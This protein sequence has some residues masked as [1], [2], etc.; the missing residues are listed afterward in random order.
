MSTH[1]NRRGLTAS[2]AGLA[3]SAAVLTPPA[4]AQI[5]PERVYY[6]IDRPVEMRVQAPAGEPGEL[7]IALFDPAGTEPIASASVAA[8]RVDLAGLFPSLWKPGAPRVRYAQ[9]LADQHRVGPPVVLQMLTTP[10]HAVADPSTGRVFFKDLP[11]TVSGLRAY[12][13][14]LVVFETDKGPITFRMRPDQAPNTVWNFLQ[15]VEGGFYTDIIFH[16]ILP[17]G[18]DGY[19]FVVQVGDPTGT[20]SGGPGYFIDLE[21][22]KL[23]HDFGVLSMARSSDPNSGGSQIFICL[24]RQATR[25][26]DGAYTSFA[27]AVSGADVIRAIQNVELADERAGKPRTPPRI[28]SARLEDAPPFGQ[29]PAP[30]SASP[31]KTKPID[32]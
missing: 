26:L 30:L 16:R 5:Q 11:E 24:S 21:P 23:P 20:G 25:H 9:L 22:S 19:P 1:G 2:V 10:S 29:G 27:E 15:L 13:D 7:A 31:S 28:V 32:R 4:Q 6:G 14:R 18:R 8:G 12:P 17:T 3:L